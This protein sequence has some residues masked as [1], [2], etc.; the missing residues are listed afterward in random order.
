MAGSSSHPSF[1]LSHRTCEHTEGSSTAG[2]QHGS[3][4]KSPLSPPQPLCPCPQGPHP[5]LLGTIPAIPTP[6]C[7]GGKGRTPASTRTSQIPPIPTSFP[8]ER[9]KSPHRPPSP[10]S[11]GTAGTERFPFPRGNALRPASASGSF[12]AH[13]TPGE[14]GMSGSDPIA[15]IVF[16]STGTGREEQKERRAVINAAPGTSEEKCLSKNS[17]VCEQSR[18]FGHGWRF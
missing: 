6:R 7:S 16:R 1:R 13:A 3:S 2:I 5:P 15:G 8:T 10:Q 18:E 9:C 11:R 17:I 4:W 14:L 12:L